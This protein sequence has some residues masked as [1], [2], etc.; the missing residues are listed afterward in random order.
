MS[1]M[2]K[3]GILLKQ[4]KSTSK[5]QSIISN[6]FTQFIQFANN[7]IV[8]CSCLQFLISSRRFWEILM[9]VET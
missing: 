3:K 6:R 2:F 7:F 9:M 4:H 1:D 8:Y 5:I